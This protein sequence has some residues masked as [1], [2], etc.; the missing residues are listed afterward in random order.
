MKIS[1]EEVYKAIDTERVYQDA[2][3]GNAKR[4][5]G[6]PPMTPGE[7]IL[8]MKQCLNRAIETWYKPN[9]GTACL[10]DIRKVV[11]VGVQCMERYGAPHR[12]V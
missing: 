3:M 10:E 1:R 11:A 12:V 2:G 4:H 7:H 6:M 9:G 8:C 5:Q